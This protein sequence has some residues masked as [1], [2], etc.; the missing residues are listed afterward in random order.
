V[1][2][3]FG[4][5]ALRALATAAAAR[6]TGGGL[7]YVAARSRSRERWLRTNYRGRQVSLAGG[8]SL[9]VAACAGVAAS[10]AEPR[11]RDAAL[12]AGGVAALAGALDDVAGSASARGLRG[13][14]GALRHGDLTTGGV[15]VGAIGMAGLVAGW[16]LGD[17]GIVQRLA[18]AA[19]VAGSANAANLF[20]VRPGRA[21]KAA[22]MIAG[23]VAVGSRAGA[24]VAGAVAGAAVGCLPGDL[25][26]RT[27]LGDAGANCLGAM[28]GVALVAGASRRRLLTSAALVV[29]LTLASEFVSFSAVIDGSPS[30]RCLDRLGRLAEPV[31][32]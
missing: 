4:R 2:G 20:D 15:K 18:T 24:D 14:L 16:R 12:I 26:E 6:A 13:H 31:D 27:M 22:L 9:I 19:T 21:L 11:A 25:G 17:G 30:L 32:A 28:L 1:S 5:V 10:G 7:G 23:P 3:G 8:P 29:A